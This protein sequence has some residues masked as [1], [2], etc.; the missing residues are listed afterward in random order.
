MSAVRVLV[1]GGRDYRNRE[2]VYYVLD[3]YH[4]KHGPIQCVIQGA[5]DGADRWAAEWG[6]DRGVG[7]ASFPADWKT[8]GAAAGPIRNQQMLD[9]ARPTVV[10]AFPG[11]R[12]TANM[13]RQARRRV[14]PVFEI[15]DADPSGERGPVA[16][17][18]V[19]ET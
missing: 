8:Y 16:G 13:V 2:R 6:F 7:V 9:E 18:N 12:G 3:R 19:A 4:A 15:P 1:C 17:R 14:L 5:A 11:G 10:I